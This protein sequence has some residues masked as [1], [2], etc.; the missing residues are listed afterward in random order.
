MEL[1]SQFGSGLAEALTPVNL[2]YAFLGVLVGTVVGVLPGIGPIT[3]IALLI[4]LSFGLEPTSGLILLSGVYYGSMYGGS[5][6]SILIRTP[7]EVASVVT[8][9]EGYEMAKRGRAGPALATAAVGS[10]VAGTLSVVGLMLL[11][12]VLVEIA[13]AFGSAEYCSWCSRFR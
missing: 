1:L 8:T 2:M 3:A 12:P 10:F 7:G 6:T 13:V 4:P 9:L 5:T 11:S